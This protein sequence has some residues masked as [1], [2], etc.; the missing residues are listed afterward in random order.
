MRGMKKRKQEIE[1]NGAEK[2][3]ETDTIESNMTD[4]RRV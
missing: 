1:K 4:K 2:R 3:K